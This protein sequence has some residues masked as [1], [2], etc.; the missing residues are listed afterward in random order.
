MLDSK[1]TKFGCECDGLIVLRIVEQIMIINCSENSNTLLSTSAGTS[2]YLIYLEKPRARTDSSPDH[3]PFQH[4]SCRA[5]L[6]FYHPIFGKH[7]KSI[8][9][10]IIIYVARWTGLVARF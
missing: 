6:D 10:H 8:I 5:R 3:R 7:L 4:V 2:C 1:M 9:K